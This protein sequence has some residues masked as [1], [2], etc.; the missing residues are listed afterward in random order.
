M[1]GGTLSPMDPSQIIP[2]QVR[3]W[4]SLADE[5]HFCH[6]LNT[7]W[8]MR[9][10]DSKTRI[11]DLGCGYGRTLFELQRGGYTNT[12]GIDF[13]LR[14]LKRCRCQIPD[15]SLVQNDGRSIPLQEY[16]VDLVL[17]FAV[18][19]CIPHDED[20]R[21]LLREIGRVLRPGGLVYI[22]DLLLNHDLRNLERYN[23][24]A[25][26]YGT[27]GVFKLPEGLVVRHHTKEWIEELT[28]SFGR[29]EF[30]DFEVTTMNGN[31]SAAFQYLGGSVQLRDGQRSKPV[32]DVC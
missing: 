29:L 22:S 5:K 20:Q 3:Y 14:M 6:P 24:Y 7:T 15:V 28:S 13:S 19:T 2:A 12:I 30:E 4:D 1:F 8:L 26:Q 27:Y 21:N 18:L 16:S 23:R 31:K 10:A 32:R 17:L 9:Y 11:L 25:G